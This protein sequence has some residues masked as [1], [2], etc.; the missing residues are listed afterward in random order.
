MNRGVIRLNVSLLHEML[1]LPPTVRIIDIGANFA[2]SSDGEL[3]LFVEAPG[4]PASR[5]GDA[6]PTLTP[7]Y[8]RLP[9][10]RPVLNRIEGLEP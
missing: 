5:L 10:G 8:D 4:I 3:A 1:L 9:S 6:I 2:S 7:V